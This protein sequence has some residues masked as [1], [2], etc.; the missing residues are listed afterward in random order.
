M[1]AVFVSACLCLAVAGPVG[2]AQEH[3]LYVVH[4]ERAKPSLLKEYEAS[5]REFVALVTKNKASMP[6]F[7][8][9]ALQGDG[10][11]YSYVAKIGNYAGLD[12][13]NQDFAALAQKDGAAFS[14]LMRRGGATFES[15]SESVVGLYPELSYTPPA[16]RLKFE[17]AR[18]FHY[19]IYH[20]MPGREEDA[21]ALAQEFLAL[22]KSKNVP[23]GYRLFK[24]ALGPEMPSIIVETAA[25]DAADY[26]AQDASDRALLGDAGQA[27]FARAFALT[28]RFETRNGWLRPDLSVFPP[29]PAKK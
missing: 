6:N 2:L 11:V 10:L 3:P 28:R 5:T 25:K 23:N 20:V 9:V 16:P 22:F 1:R 8:F 29:A 26:A 17:D 7:S 15:V 4:Q 14:E 21:D 13:I 19:D 27:L 18:Y 24:S 12:L